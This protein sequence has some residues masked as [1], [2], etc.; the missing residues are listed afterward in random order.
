VGSKNRHTRGAKPV[1]ENFAF[2]CTQHI[3]DQELEAVA[4]YLVLQMGEDITEEALAGLVFKKMIEAII[5]NAPTL[6]KLL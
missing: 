2:E 3:L 1:M 4:A 5:D 6:W